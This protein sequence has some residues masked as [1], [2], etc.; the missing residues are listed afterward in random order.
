MN[1]PAARRRSAS[2]RPLDWLRFL[3][4]PAPDGLELQFED[5]YYGPPNVTPPK[6]EHTKFVLKFG[7][8]HANEGLLVHWLAGVGRSST[9][10]LFVLA[11]RYRPGPEADSLEELL[12]LR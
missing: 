12:R 11:D 7:R 6:R 10:A 8:K 4:E 3:V 2:A 5:P 9:A 1:L